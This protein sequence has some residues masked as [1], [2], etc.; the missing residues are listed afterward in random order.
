MLRPLRAG[1]RVV[2]DGLGPGLAGLDVGERVIVVDVVAPVDERQVGQRAGVERVVE[3]LQRVH[4]RI[5]RPPVERAA[6][7]IAVAVRAP[8]EAAVHHELHDRRRVRRRKR[9]AGV[10]HAGVG[11]RRAG[12]CGCRTC[13]W[14]SARS[15][16]RRCANVVGQPVVE[17]EVGLVVLPHDEVPSVPVVWAALITKPSIVPSLM[18]VSTD[19]DWWPGSC[20]MQVVVACDGKTGLPCRSGFE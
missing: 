8:G 5:R 2:V 11:A 6:R 19:A 18:L 13:R 4:A 20:G 10:D 7:G 12:S 9:D 14:P 15:A 3:V 16:G 1:D 17:R